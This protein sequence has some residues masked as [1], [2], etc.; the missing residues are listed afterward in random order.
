MGIDLIDHLVQRDPHGAD[1]LECSVA[2]MKAQKPVSLANSEADSSVL[3]NS[4]SVS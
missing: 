4:V 1:E 2:G 3:E